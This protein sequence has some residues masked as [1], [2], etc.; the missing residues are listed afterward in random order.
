MQTVFL[1]NQL[2]GKCNYRFSQVN[3]IYTSSGLTRGPSF[4]YYFFAVNSLH[5]QRIH[6][7]TETHLSSNKHLP[8]ICASVV[9]TF[10]DRKE[11]GY[12]YKTYKSFRNLPL[13]MKISEKFFCNNCVSGAVMFITWVC[14]LPTV[15]NP[16]GTPLQVSAALQQSSPWPAGC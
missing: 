16:V 13:G 11:D 4:P 14:P 3:R 10:V 1:L 12:W 7:Y 6:I 8:L 5:T 9:P 15:V 2:N